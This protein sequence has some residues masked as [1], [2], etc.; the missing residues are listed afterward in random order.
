MTKKFLDNMQLYHSST[1]FFCVKVRAA[2]KRLG[3][4]I[5]LKNIQFGSKNKAELIRGGGK[6][7]VPCLRIQENNEERWMYESD[8]IIEFLEQQCN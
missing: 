3:I 6:K 8:D 7:Q 2:M 4:K 5:K 1:C